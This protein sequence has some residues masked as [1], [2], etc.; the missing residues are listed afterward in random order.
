MHT[1]IRSISAIALTGIVASLA[2]CATP[3][4]FAAKDE[5]PLLNFRSCAKP[6]YPAESFTAR[7]EGTVTLNFEV[8]ADGTISGST[9]K[10]SSGYRLLDEAAHQA[11]KK[12]TFAPA[13]KNGTAIKANADVQYVWTLKEPVDVKGIEKR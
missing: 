5:R 2:A 6:M 9:V 7:H 12:C 1:A 11:I 13:I 4:A 10:Q 3:S 8:E